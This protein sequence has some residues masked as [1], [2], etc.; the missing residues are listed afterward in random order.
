[1]PRTRCP[2]TLRPVEPLHAIA[3]VAFGLAGGVMGGLLGVGGSVIIIPLATIILAPDKQQLQGAAMISN[4]A[5]AVSAYH[6]YAKAGRIEWT[7]AGRI[8]PSAIACVLAG[9][10]ASLFVDAALFR[11]LFAVFL[12]LIAVREFRL[13]A[14]PGDHTDDD[15]RELT[16]ARGAGVGAVM[17]FLSGLLGIGGGV[18]GIPLMRAW[19]HLPMKRAVVTSVCVMM[20]LT[21]VG[22]TLK[23]V[24][25]A[26]TPVEGG[27]N[28][29]VP[30]IMIAACLV[31]TAMIGSWLGASLNVRI[32]GRAVRWVLAT[33]LP[34]SAVWMAWPIV[35][36]WIANAQR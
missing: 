26:R 34:V 30:T 2:A 36:Q 24:T 27:G 7:Y 28:A 22:A 33:F 25:L 3:F 11:V 21:M 35:A 29:L 12:L 23:A 5:V 16:T 13:L 17:G 20:P 10:T 1:M 14:H 15:A 9:V 8:W 4:I 18:A 6:R 19:A 31:P 32:T